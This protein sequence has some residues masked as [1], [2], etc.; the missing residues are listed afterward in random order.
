MRLGQTYMG[1]HYIELSAQDA[2]LVK[3]ALLRAGP[4]AR[5]FETTKIDKMLGIYVTEPTQSEWASPLAFSQKN[6]CLLRFYIE[7]KKR[8]TVTV[9]NTYA[10]LPMDKCFDSLDEVCVAPPVET[11]SAY[12][13]N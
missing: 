11:D 8:K 12:C 6:N 1:K 5:E 9:K 10:I 4:K 13:P 3:L 7:Q 2:C